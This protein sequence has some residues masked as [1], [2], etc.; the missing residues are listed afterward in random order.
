[1]LP[2]QFLNPKR[3][4]IQLYNC[5]RHHACCCLLLPH[6]CR[7]TAARLP[8]HCRTTATA[9]YCIFFRIASGGKRFYYWRRGSFPN[10]RNAHEIQRQSCGSRAAVER[11]W[12]GNRKT[13]ASV[14][15][16]LTLAPRAA[17]TLVCVGNQNPYNETGMPG[18][19][20][21][22]PQNTSRNAYRSLCSERVVA[23]MLARS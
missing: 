18:N 4:R 14:V 20:Q 9:I 13:S 6:D 11:Q 23:A 8:H 19:M 15:I 12:S 2:T 10:C 21:L 1:M 22:K 16:T 17:A 3:L 7:T 5:V